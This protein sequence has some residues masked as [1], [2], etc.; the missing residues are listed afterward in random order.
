MLLKQRS[1]AHD[2]LMR[3]GRVTAEMHGVGNFNR[4]GQYVKVLLAQ[5]LTP[6]LQR[7]LT[8]PQR[9]RVRTPQPQ[10]PYLVDDEAAQGDVVGVE[11]PAGSGLQMLERQIVGGVIAAAVGVARV[12]FGQQDV[13]GGAVGVEH[14]RA[15]LPKSVSCDR[16]DDAV[17]LDKVSGAVELHQ[18]QSVQ[19]ARGGAESPL[20]GQELEDAGR[21]LCSLGTSREQLGRDRLRGEERAQVEQV[22][23]VRR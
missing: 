17:H 19:L 12:G 16:L 2:Q 15:D 22:L 13:N 7:L 6:D 9:L 8:E 4:H 10:A 3:V 23:S 18:R 14:V 1:Y 5:A 21:I 11:E 20:I